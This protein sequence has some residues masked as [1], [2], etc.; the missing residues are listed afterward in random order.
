MRLPL[1]LWEG[2]TRWLVCL[3]LQAVSST[4]RVGDLVGLLRSVAQRLPQD[5][6][7]NKDKKNRKIERMDE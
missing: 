2:R 6:L 4:G 7:P 1:P 3:P 5:L